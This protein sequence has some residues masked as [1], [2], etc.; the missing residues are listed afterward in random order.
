MR[1][2]VDA[3]SG[4]NAPVET[5]KGAIAA[6]KEFDVNIVLSGNREVIVKTASELGESL[7]GIEILDADEVITMNDDPNCV[8]RSK[9]NSSMSVGLRELKENGDAFISAGNTGALLVGATLIV[10][11]MKGIRRPCIVTV[12]PFP[13]PILLADSGANINVLPEYL[14]TWALMSSVYAK[15]VLSVADPR[16]GLLNNGAEE[17]KGTQ[18]LVDTY[19]LLKNSNDINFVGNIEGRDVPFGMCD[20]LIT[21]GFTGNVLLKYTEGFGKFFLKT[22]KGMYTK[23]LRSKLSYLAMKDQLDELKTV[24]DAGS[25]GGA[26]L[27]GLKKPVFKAHGSS[28]ATAIKNAVAKAVSYVEND[29][30][31]K[32][33]L[34]IAEKNEKSENEAVADNNK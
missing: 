29:V 26:P 25:F 10:R 22:L 27:L 8:V 23:N 4:D 6:S 2:I 34:G 28:D 14:E 3:M 5:V 15:N 17:H 32:I 16:V 21:D 33:A 30:T 13:T 18:T 31:G 9:K 20:V 7:D 24:F 12:L 11:A 19:Q 1:I